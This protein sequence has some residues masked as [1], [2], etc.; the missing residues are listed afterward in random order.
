M[1]E[2][3]SFFFEKINALVNFWLPKNFRV[4]L[5]PDKLLLC[6]QEPDPANSQ[7]NP[8]YTP[9]PIPLALVL[10]ACLIFIQKE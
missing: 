6:L 2:V 7:L 9:Y 5:E 8:V 1:A 4:N 10:S 3:H